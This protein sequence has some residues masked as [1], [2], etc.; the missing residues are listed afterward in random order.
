[1]KKIKLIS[2]AIFLLAFTNIS[3][4]QCKYSVKEVDKFTGTTKIETTSEVLH[5]DF[6]SAL[7]FSFCKH[8]SLL[9]VKVGVNLNDEIYSIVKDDKLLLICGESTISLH[10]L[11]TKVVQGFVYVNYLITKDQLNVLNLYNISDI[12]IYLRDS[13]IEKSITAKRAD[14]IMQLSKCILN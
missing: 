3:F 2:T 4:G 1:M 13:Y 10:S 7:S 11:E 12:R 14:K 6:N 9:F 5:R 8:D